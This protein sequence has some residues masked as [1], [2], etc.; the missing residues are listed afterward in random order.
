MAEIDYTRMII[1][2]IHKVVKVIKK[3]MSNSEEKEK[4]KNGK[5]TS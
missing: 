1:K 4:K 2:V 3:E 5:D